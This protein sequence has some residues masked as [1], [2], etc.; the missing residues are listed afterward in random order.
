MPDRRKLIMFVIVIAC[1]GCFYV[2][3]YFLP[4]RIG[5][6]SI[7]RYPYSTAYQL[8]FLSMLVALISYRFVYV[9]SRGNAFGDLARGAVYGYVASL[10]AYIFAYSFFYVSGFSIIGVERLIDLLVDSP[11]RNT[12]Q[13]LVYP[14]LLL[15]W[16]YGIL[17]VLMIK[18]VG[19][20][21]LGQDTRT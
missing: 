21:V 6:H 16:A 1:I 18:G 5:L 14:L 4:W 9:G 3:G 12:F 10:V 7:E 20:K 13:F 8:A 17:V 11:V 15:G 2:A 19:S